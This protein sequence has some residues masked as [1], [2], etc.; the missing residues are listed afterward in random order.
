MTLSPRLLRCSARSAYIKF[1]SKA[2]ELIYRILDYD[3]MMERHRNIEAL[4]AGGQD[5]SMVHNLSAID[6]ES[7]MMQEFAAFDTAGAGVLPMASVNS[8]LAGSSM[9]L[10]A[11]EISALLSAVEVD[12]SGMVLYSS[13]AN[14]AY[15]I[16][17]YIA[18]QAAATG[19]M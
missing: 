3:S 13:L 4:T 7:T 6:V 11:M 18:E 5:F 15:Y 9:G 1:A 2:A 16:L 12:A 17:Q 19:M 8:A 14:Y 10:N